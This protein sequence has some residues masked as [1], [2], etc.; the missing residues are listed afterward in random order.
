MWFT[1]S[2]TDH[3]R[4]RGDA[5]P[6]L[7]RSV[8]LAGIAVAWV[9]SALPAVAN[10]TAER[11]ETA[12]RLYQSSCSACH[13]SDGRGLPAAT[14]GFETPVPDFTDCNF[15]T[16][17]PD[18]DWYAIVHE[19]GP[20]RAFDRMMPGFGPALAP[21]EMS[22]IL[23][24]VRTF[25][26]DGAWPRGE[27]NLPRLLVTSKAYPEDEAVLTVTA[28]A[29]GSGF[30]TPTLIYERRIGARNQVEIAMP[31]VAS[32][33]AEGDWIGGVGDIALSAKR[34]LFHSLD[35][36]SISSAA[37]EVILPTGHEDKGFGS[38]TTI[39]EPFLAFGQI[40]PSAGFLQLQAGV[41]LPADR[42]R[43]D[44]AFGRIGI[45]KTFVQGRFGRTWSPMVEILA[46]RDLDASEH[47]PLGCGAA[48]PGEPEH[49]PTLAG[50][51]R[52]AAPDER[53]RP[54]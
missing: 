50:V 47:R 10:T 6:V 18:E 27:L 28:N 3:H 40:L 2:T 36:G 25:C 46:A 51:R 33:R 38:G 42:D 43:S 15:A 52:R 29:E 44:E 37:F 1:P 21:E 7:E 16:R 48:T 17:E 5:D 41:E 24:H 35:A 49:A 4:R 19:G 34:A 14:V 8:L 13:G 30:V 11:R 53:R 26:D 22:L 31:F 32:E 39:F 23:E 45:G 9:S 54:T 12:K 20:V